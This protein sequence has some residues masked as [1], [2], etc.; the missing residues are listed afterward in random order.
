MSRL[1]DTRFQ[2]ESRACRKWMIIKDKDKSR[3]SNLQPKVQ[4]ILRL[5]WI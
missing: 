2:G 1:A 5:Q 4:K 3:K